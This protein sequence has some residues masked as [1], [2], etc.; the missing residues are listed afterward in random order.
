MALLPMGGFEPP[1]FLAW[2]RGSRD[3]LVWSNGAVKSQEI[4]LLLSRF[5][6]KGQRFKPS[7]VWYNFSSRNRS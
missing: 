1:I 2:N 6:G 5:S 7:I 4:R 3:C